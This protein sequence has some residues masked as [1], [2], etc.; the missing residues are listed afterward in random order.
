LEEH[1]KYQIPT[2]SQIAEITKGQNIK[3]QYSG[4]IEINKYLFRLF[5]FDPKIKFVRKTVY[6]LKLLFNLMTNWILYPILTNKKY[7]PDVNR[8]YLQILKEGN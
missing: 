6:Y 3:L 2:Q 8:A 5:L 7:G 1:V 4:N